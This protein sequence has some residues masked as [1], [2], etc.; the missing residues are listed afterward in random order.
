MAVGLVWMGGL[1]GAAAANPAA[2]QAAI[3][4]QNRNTPA[5]MRL[6][7]VVGTAVGL[8]VQ[9]QP[10]I[11]VFTEFP[12][13][14]GIP[15]RVEGLPVR[16]EVTGMFVA[17][18][19]SSPR[20][21]WTRPVPIGVSTGH[22]QIT[23]GTL[24]CRVVDSEGN[25]YALSNN[26]VFA[27][28]NNASVGD[29]W[30]LDDGDIVLQPGPYDGGVW[31]TDRI[32]WLFD[33]EPILFG[34]A[35]NVMDAA[36]AYADCSD[37]GSHTPGD[38]Y[39]APGTVPVAASLGMAV[40]K[41]GR[42]TGR[43]FGT[44]DGINA[45]VNVCYELR[46]PVRCVKLATFV[47]QIIITPGAFSAGG[48][49]GSLIVTQDE[50][51]SPV[52]LLF[53]G[54]S[55]STIANPIG[56]VLARFG[57][58][59]DNTTGCDPGGDD[60]PP[61]EENDPPVVGIQSPGDGGVFAYNAIITFSG[62]A[63]DPEDGNLSGLLQWTSSVQGEIG[64]GGGFSRSLD[65]GLHTI[66]A[67]VT[68]SGNL[69]G[70]ASVDITVEAPPPPSGITLTAVGYK[71]RGRQSVDLNWSGAS[72]THVTLI[73]NGVTVGSIPNTGSYTDNLNAVGGGSYTYQVCEGL[74]CS[75]TA[76]V[77]F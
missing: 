77:T 23:A 38:G 29:P 60:D 6:P 52:G 37:V 27:N 74:T 3:Q 48:D 32:G 10:E 13:V 49:S 2:V 5:L 47:G 46:G 44:V 66:T 72:A 65:A 70:S 73:R 14:G 9:G 69:T 75:N 51:R 28:S 30:I 62:S 59:V 41:Y 26:H 76:Q 67:S 55:V 20:D 42:T 43:T 31:P 17:R 54:S 56:P 21:I 57:V 4:A 12:G 58:T 7:G 50:S 35:N 22:R 53:A 15:A 61:V 71:V 68:D 18:L 45:T 11:R 8:D 24:G 19:D 34:G 1:A 36:I 33:F 63:M 25:L 16:A 40:Q 39:G 64:A